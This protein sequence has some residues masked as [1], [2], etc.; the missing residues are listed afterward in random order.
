SRSYG[1]N[2]HVIRNATNYFTFSGRSGAEI[3]GPLQTVLRLKRP[4][5]GYVGW[6]NSLRLDE[7]LIHFVATARPDWQ[8]VF[9]GP[10]A[11]PLPLGAKIPQLKNVHFLKS[12]PYERLP[13]FLTA[14]DACI[15]PNRIN[16]H[17]EGNDPIKI[18]DYL[19][20]GKPVVSTATNGTKEFQ[21]E[22]VIAHG[23]QEFL[24]GLES[25]LSND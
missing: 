3:L 20:S 15:L 23:H 19:A 6:L 16:S 14:L 25:V 10:K 8:F 9:M 12:V 1:A 22:L 2:A 18:Y 17:T 4:V 21:N 5:I 13:A 24:Q 11:D 7:D